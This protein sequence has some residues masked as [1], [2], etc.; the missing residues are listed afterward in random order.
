MDR[1]RIPFI[2]LA[3]GAW[4]NIQMCLDN[5]LSFSLSK[6]WPAEIVGKSVNDSMLTTL[7]DLG[8]ELKGLSTNVD[9][10]AI[11]DFTKVLVNISHSETD[12]ENTFTLTA[13]D[14]LR[15]VNKEPLV[16][17]IKSLPNG[18]DVAQPMNAER[19]STTI[20]LTVILKGDISKVSYQYQAYGYWQPLFPTTIESDTERISNHHVQR[21]VA[22]TTTDKSNCGR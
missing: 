4:R 14:K 13:T 19:G 10:M 9:K 18:F 15:K 12:E 11:L 8:L 2:S 21:R 1:T 17:K 6:G 3:D 16:L 22:E 5:P 7:Q 20:L